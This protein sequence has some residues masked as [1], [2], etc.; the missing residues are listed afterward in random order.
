MLTFNEKEN[1]KRKHMKHKQKRK[2][3]DEAV[4]KKQRIKHAKIEQEQLLEKKL[5]QSHNF[6]KNSAQEI[7]SFDKFEIMK[8]QI[9]EIHRMKSMQSDEEETDVFADNESYIE[10]NGKHLN[11]SRLVKSESHQ[12]S[13]LEQVLEKIEKKKKDKT[14][15]F[16]QEIKKNKQYTKKMALYCDYVQIGEYAYQEQLAQVCL[17]NELNA[18]VYLQ[19][20]RPEQEITDYRTDETGLTSISFTY[21]KPL[22]EILQ[23]LTSILIDATRAHKKRILIGHNLSHHIHHLFGKYNI[24]MQR[25]ISLFS[26]VYKCALPRTPNAKSIIENKDIPD[27]LPIENLSTMTAKYIGITP[28]ILMHDPVLKAQC[29]MRIY[30]MFE[31][32]YDAFFA[33][34]AAIQQLNESNSIAKASS[35]NKKFNRGKSLQNK[36]QGIEEIKHRI[37]IQ[38]QLNSTIDSLLQQLKK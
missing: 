9:Q 20:V 24:Q 38:H 22:A 3:R 15:N 1:K 5:E 13:I 36:N 2:V 35:G 37:T 12:L 8:Q 6:T 16:Q 17:V 11:E 4:L 14:S 33:K 31:A 18:C 27:Q 34:N 23:D 32:D 7:G 10:Q 30:K 28:D 29:I 21:S 26:P 19:R 25:D